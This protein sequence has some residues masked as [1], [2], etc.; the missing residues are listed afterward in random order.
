MLLG[1]T[2]ILVHMQTDKYIHHAY[3][4]TK[5]H[6]NIHNVIRFLSSYKIM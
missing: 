6:D 5:V 1:H 4:H 3:T 2:H